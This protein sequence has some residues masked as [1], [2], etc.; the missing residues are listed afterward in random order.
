MTLRPVAR[1]AARNLFAAAALLGAAA[2][3]SGPVAAQTP[4]DT[5]EYLRQF[6]TDG[7][8]RVSLSEFQNYMSRGFV[9]MDRN[10]DGILTADELPRG[11]R[12]R[13][14]PTLEARLRELSAA[15]DRQD[16]NNDGYLDAREMAAP[17]Q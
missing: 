1:H 5:R 17:P 2:F 16:I 3:V 13:K 7:D 12:A 14:T 15:F 4:R 6:D 11:T 10:G 8:G 9:Q